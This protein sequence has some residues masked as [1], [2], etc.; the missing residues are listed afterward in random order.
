[1]HTEESIIRDVA[2]LIVWFPFRWIIQAV[3]VSLGFFT[4][5]VLGDIHYFLSRKRRS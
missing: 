1:M 3:P 4:F 5:K 2:R